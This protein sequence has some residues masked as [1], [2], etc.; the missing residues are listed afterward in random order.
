MRRRVQRGEVIVRTGQPF[1]YLIR[2]GSGL[3]LS[4]A[5]GRVTGLHLP[6]DIVGVGG[7]AG[8]VHPFDVHALESGHV[9]LAPFA[10][11][12]Q[13]AGTEPQLLKALHRAM[14]AEML[15]QHQLV[16]LL[17]HP[18]AE[19]RLAAFLADLWTR[20]AYKG[21]AEFVLLSLSRAEIGSYLGLTMESISRGF[22]RLARRGLVDVRRRRLRVVDLPRLGM[23]ATEHRRAN[24]STQVV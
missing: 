12:E 10:L 23:F 20:R 5:H 11:I 7:L 24:A 22:A 17:T 19:G 6:G 18:S 14:S 21:D 1:E 15:R 2:P 13:L 9:R 16:A 3:L 4:T 8:G